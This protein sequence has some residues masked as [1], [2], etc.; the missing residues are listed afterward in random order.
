MLSNAF[1]LQAGASRDLFDAMEHQQ[2]AENFPLKP[3]RQQ[4]D[5]LRVSYET[6][7][8]SAFQMAPQPI[9]KLCADHPAVH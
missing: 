7:A 2:L 3:N 1:G 5:P 6:L 8:N 4:P 9:P